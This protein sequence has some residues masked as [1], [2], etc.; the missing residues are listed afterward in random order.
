MTRRPLAFLSLPLSLALTL[1]ACGDDNPAGDGNDTGT[2]DEVG[3]MDTTTDA[4]TSTT[5]DTTTDAETTTD[6][7][8]PPDSDQDG[9]PDA[10]DNCPDDPN[11]NQLDFDGNG[12]GN[13]CD[14][15]SFTMGG[16]TLASSAQA[17][18]GNLGGCDIPIDFEVLGG[19]V[20]LQ[21]DDNATLVKVEVVSM[22]IADILDQDCEINFLLTATV[23][24]TDIMMMNNGADFPVS[25]GHNQADH[26]AGVAMGMTN[27]PHPV[28]TTAQITATTDPNMPGMPSDLN[29]DG[30][31]PP[32]A[33][34]ATG[35]G[36]SLD[37]TFDDANFVIA[38]DTFMVT[39]PIQ[40]DIDFQLRGLQGTVTL[41]P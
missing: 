24:L 13:V 32:M 33:V 22:E 39:D 35:A 23:S 2:E 6:D 17:Q 40:V 34:D 9:I 20:D 10:D 7:A 14:V 11:P 3:T 27:I 25:F 28:L 36:A 19:Q 41:T 16:G 38:M 1:A 5:A 4:E 15:T 29:L 31:L 12:A 30:N 8:P 37:L 26:D 18:A 21:F